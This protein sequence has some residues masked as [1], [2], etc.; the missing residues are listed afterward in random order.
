MISCLPGSPA[1]CWVTRIDWMIS[2]SLRSSD[3]V[4][5]LDQVVVEE[6]RPDELL[7]DRRGAAAVA[8]QRVE[9]GRDDRDG[10]EAGVLPERLVLDRRRRVEQDRR[11]L[12]ELDDLAL[13]VAEAGELV[14]GAVVDDRLL[15]QLVVV[16]SVTG[17]RPVASAV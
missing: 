6:A 4:R 11:D 12:L 1:K 10:I 14:A 13:G 15:G 8:A 5:V 3:P 2:L 7:G 9:A 16:M 17:L